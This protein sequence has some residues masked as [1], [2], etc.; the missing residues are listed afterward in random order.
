[1]YYAAHGVVGCVGEEGESAFSTF[2]EFGDF[3]NTA[4]VARES[5]RDR[6]TTGYEPFELPPVCLQNRVFGM[7]WCGRHRVWEGYH[8]SRRSSRD[9]YPV[10]CHQVY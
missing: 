2:Q 8:E 9:T 5:E 10:I 6:E 7:W 4:Q 3:A 1:M